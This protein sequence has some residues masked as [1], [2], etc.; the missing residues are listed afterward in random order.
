[1]KSLIRSYLNE[2]LG[3]DLF[4]Y[5]LC[6]RYP[7]I[8]FAIVGENQFKGIT[9]EISNLKFIS[10][11]AKHNK[12]INKI[13]KLNQRIHKQKICNRRDIVMYNVLSRF[14]HENIFVTGSYFIQNPEWSCMEDAGWYDSKPHILGCNF[15]PYTDGKYFIEHKKQFAKCKEIGFRESYSYDMFSD[16]SNVFCAPDL[17]FALEQ[18]SIKSVSNNEY[19]VSVVNLAK[20]NDAELMR[21]Q[22]SYVQLLVDIISALRSSN[23][24][25]TLMSFCSRQGDDDVIDEVLSKLDGVE[26]INTFYY[27]EEGINKSLEKLKGCK[28]IIASRY[29]AMILGFLFGKEVLPVAY[30]KKMNNVLEDLKYNGTILSVSDSLSAN[31]EV[32]NLFGRLDSEILEKTV[33]NTQRHFRM[34]DDKFRRS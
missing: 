19:I 7:K 20:D 32:K 16:L 15:G 28:G 21:L 2:N 11:D 26:D 8:K 9:D 22:E 24:K 1:M 29:H 10:E 14:Y 17:V 5:I 18:A 27:R 25:V 3:D 34:L 31:T 33:E 30:S 6:H 4:V 23:E 13:Y 12:I